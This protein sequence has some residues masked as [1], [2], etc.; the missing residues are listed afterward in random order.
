MRE[1][2][3]QEKLLKLTI[4]Y[5]IGRMILEWFAA[6]DKS[7]VCLCVKSNNV[8]R[9]PKRRKISQRDDTD[10]QIIPYINPTFVSY[11]D[12]STFTI[13][14]MTFESHRQL[15]PFHIEKSDYTNPIRDIIPVN[16]YMTYPHIMN[17]DSNKC[18]TNHINRTRDISLTD[19]KKLSN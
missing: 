17:T 6:I 8:P 5:R 12:S 13:D 11:F 19:S 3:A 7:T 10:L 15:E 18:L 1:D 9:S 16:K 4:C 14:K 2:F